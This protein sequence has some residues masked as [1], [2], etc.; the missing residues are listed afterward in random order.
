MTTKSDVY[1]FR[2]Q[3]ETP[4]IPTIRT[5]YGV[6]AKDQSAAAICN[7]LQEAG[8]ETDLINDT[9]GWFFIKAKNV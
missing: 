6:K 1:A 8:F 7:Q 3:V 2:L 4:E 9:K 5:I